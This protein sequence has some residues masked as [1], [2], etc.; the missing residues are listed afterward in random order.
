MKRIFK[1]LFAVLMSVICITSCTYEPPYANVE[2]LSRITGVEL[3]EYTVVSD[4]LVWSNWMGDSGSI[5]IIEFKEQPAEA[6]YASL[7]SM[8][9]SDSQYWSTKNNGAS[10]WFHRSWGNGYP[11]PEGEDPKYDNYI[12]VEIPREGKT[13]K[14]T[15][16]MW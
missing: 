3:P 6:F 9:V 5:M 1:C 2:R 16:G 13:V 14:V 11:A 8:V 4:S 12:E 7:D 15:Y 10:W